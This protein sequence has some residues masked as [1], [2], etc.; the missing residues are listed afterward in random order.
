MFNHNLNY[1]IPGAQP[2]APIYREGIFVVVLVVVLVAV[3]KTSR[4]VRKTSI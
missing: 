3:R 1:T 2:P 4:C